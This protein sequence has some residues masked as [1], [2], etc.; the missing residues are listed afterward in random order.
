MI[1]FLSDD[2][3]TQKVLIESIESDKYGY[4]ITLN[5]IGGCHSFNQNALCS[6]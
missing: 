2:R 6:K 3:R 5:T 4:A 1:N